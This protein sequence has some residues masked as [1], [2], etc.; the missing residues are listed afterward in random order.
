MSRM[1]VSEELRR[2]KEL[3]DND[4][5]LQAAL[6]LS[7]VDLFRGTSSDVSLIDLGFSPPA[8]SKGGIHDDLAGLDS[9]KPIQ[10]QNPF[11]EP[12]RR[13]STNPFDD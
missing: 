2:R 8:V 5:D 4:P 9:F 3:E 1:E 12:L 7:R 11:Q 13:K 10:V 6:A